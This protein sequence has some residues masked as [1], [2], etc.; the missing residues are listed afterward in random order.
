MMRQRM[1][2]M[3]AA[4]LL[5]CVPSFAVDAVIEGPS[6]AFV[7]DLV[8]LNT[9]KSVGDNKLWI[10]DPSI[11]GKT[12]QCGD[13]L[14]FAVG[15]PGKYYFTLVVADKE[16][17]IDYQLHM[18]EITSQPPVVNPPTDPPTNPPVDPPKPPPS[19][20]LQSFI[21]LSRSSAAA[22]AD[23][24]TTLALADALEAAITRAANMALTDA[25]AE[26]GKTFESVML[27]R[28]GASADKPWL[29]DFRKPIEAAI[30]SSMPTTTQ[31][32]LQ[33]QRAIVQGLRAA[34]QTSS[35]TNVSKVTMLSRPG[36][37]YCDRWKQLIKPHLENAGWT[38]HEQLDT[39]GPVPSFSVCASGRCVSYTGFMDLKTF[40]GIVQSIR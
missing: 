19:S 23:A 10:L 4:A 20:D 18:V 3:L 30:Q 24:P 32:Y 40:N 13:S 37:V 36:C 27:A 17:K 35:S 9:T 14:A 16:A 11:A 26:C 7:G 5:L 15:L 31:Q 33:I 6:T 8:V 34:L 2:S 29:F 22:L 25:A 28:R 12:I 1:L 39:T 38:V 21:D